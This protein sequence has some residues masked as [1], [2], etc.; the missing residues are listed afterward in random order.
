MPRIKTKPAEAISFGISMKIGFLI[1]FSMP[2]IKTKPAEA[3]S[4]GI[5]MKIGF[6]ILA[7]FG[8][9]TFWKRENRLLLQICTVILFVVGV[10][11]LM[12]SVACFAKRDPL[13]E[14]DRDVLTAKLK[15][16][17]VEY[18]YNKKRQKE[19]DDMQQKYKCCGPDQPANMT[20]TT[21]LP[22]CCATLDKGQCLNPYEETCVDA[23]LDYAM[24]VRTYC[25]DLSS[26]ILQFV[27]SLV[28]LA[29]GGATTMMLEVTKPIMM[30]GTSQ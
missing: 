10:I 29:T 21:Y 1:P 18:S 16:S 24:S 12:K 2:R 20:E 22:S 5:S 13:T 30:I 19:V 26:N 25:N 4:F 14:N 3:I 15:R 8:W 11:A 9:I 7:G 23:M 17:Y 28:V 27:I 6:L